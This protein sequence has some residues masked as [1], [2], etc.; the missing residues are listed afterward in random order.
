MSA[1]PVVHSVH[2]WLPLTETWM[3]GQIEHLPAHITSHV[4][5]RRVTNR[6]QFPVEHLHAVDDLCLPRRIWEGALRRLHL[7]RHVGLLSHVAREVQASI[8]H[9][10]F[11][12]LGWENLIAAADCGARHLVTFYGYDVNFL[13]RSRP[14][15]RSRFR[16]L[17]ARVD[18]VL[19]EG[20]FMARAIAGLGCPP[21]KLIVQR[22]GVRVEQFEF[23]PRR[24]GEGEPLRVLIA[25]GF[26]EK[27]GIPDALE[28]LGLLANSL[29]VEVTLIGDASA[30]SRARAEKARVLDAARRSG[31]GSRLR[32]LGF[33]PHARLIAE[34]YRHHIFLAPSRTASDGDTEG[35]AP[36][37]LIEMAATGMP[38]VSTRHCDIPGVVEDGVTGL[39]ADEGDIQGLAER[40]RWLAGCPGRWEELGLCARHKV[41]HAFNARVQGERLAAIY[42]VIDSGRGAAAAQAATQ[43]VGPT[44]GRSDNRAEPVPSR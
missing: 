35:G 31:L 3:H 33:Q 29:A 18:G 41:E 37:G 23:R 25:G 14:R 16:E 32:W 11:G 44:V 5:C 43:R 28:A 10:H 27:K 24:R 19:C 38:V 7:R 39:L 21:E 20:P 34:A 2:H 6:D 15:W 42:R 13:P 36:V 12:D 4:V 30:D 8:I 9:S 17:F 22:L 1:L 26:R 40:L